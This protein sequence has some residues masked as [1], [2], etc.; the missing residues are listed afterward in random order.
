MLFLWLPNAKASGFDQ[1]YF[2]NMKFLLFNEQLWG[3]L[4]QWNNGKNPG[5]RERKSE[6]GFT[7]LT[8]EL[9]E[10]HCILWPW[11]SIVSTPGNIVHLPDLQALGPQLMLSMEESKSGIIIYWCKSKEKESWNLLAPGFQAYPFQEY[12]SLVWRYPYFEWHN[13]HYTNNVIISVT[14]SRYPILSKVKVAQSCPTLCNPIAYTV[15][16]ILQ[17]RILE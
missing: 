16:G 10:L 12:T 15:H 4:K 2:Y 17:A 5:H 14:F 11:K 7:F 13:R 1:V 9:C 8:K 6:Y 3:S